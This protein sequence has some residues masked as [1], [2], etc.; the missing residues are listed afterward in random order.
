MSKPSYEELLAERDA[1]AVQVKQ[2]K[3]IKPEL[4]PFPPQGSCLPRFGIKWNGQYEPISTPMDDGYWTPYHLALAQNAELAAEV[5]LLAA[6]RDEVVGVMNNS[7]GVA[8]WHHNHT[9]ATWDELFPVIPDM[10]TPA[11]CIAQVRADAGRAGF[12]AGY[13]KMHIEFVGSIAPAGSAEHAAYQY[14]ERIKQ[15]GTE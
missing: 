5:E 11:T 15:G 10:E 13:H 12:V 7:Q 9:I 2:L 6:F 1:L 3:G 4:P 14:A 8:G